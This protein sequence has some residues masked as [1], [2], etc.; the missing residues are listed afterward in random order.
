MDSR[1]LF[2][3]TEICFASLQTHR[4]FKYMARGIQE[5]YPEKPLSKG[6]YKDCNAACDDILSQQQN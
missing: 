5:L 3:E 2:Q 1:K 6:F 4:V